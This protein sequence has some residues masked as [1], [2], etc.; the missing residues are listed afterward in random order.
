MR[1]DADEMGFADGGNFHHLSDAADI[2]QGGAYKINVV[3]FDELVEVPP[4]AP[5]FA[6]CQGN[7]HFLAQDR[8]V[9][10]KGFGADRIFDE[11]RSQVL[12][13]VA[14]ANGIVEVEALVEIDHQSPS[15]PT[16]SRACAHSSRS[17]LTRSR[18]L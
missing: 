13:Q 1:N 2:G 9:L 15:L 7:I 11:E 18:V 8:N 10:Q 12:D 17:W 5:L 3:I 6:R 14:A 16:P 4:V